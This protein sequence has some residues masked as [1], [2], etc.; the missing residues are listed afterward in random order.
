M[1]LPLR[2]AQIFYLVLV[3]GLGA[4]LLLEVGPLLGKA[5]T[6]PSLL[7][8]YLLLAMVAVG[9]VSWLITCLIDPGYVVAPPADGGGRHA[10]DTYE[11][12]GLL[13]TEKVC[14]TCHVV[15]PPRSK[16]CR[17]CNRCV[18]RFDHHCGWMNSCV[19]ERN[20]P[21]FLLF[22]LIHSTACVFGSYLSAAVLGGECEAFLDIIRE[23]RRASGAAP[24]V[25]SWTTCVAYSV[26]HHRVVVF[27]FILLLVIGIVL[28]LFF[29]FHA[30]LVYRNTTTNEKFK[31]EDLKEDMKEY[32]ERLETDVRDAEAEQAEPGAKPAPS[33]RELYMRD[34]VVLRGEAIAGNDED[35]GCE[36]AAASS[37]ED[38]GGDEEEDD[39]D[40]PAEGARRR[41]H[42][43]RGDE[44][45]RNSG[46]T[47]ADLARRPWLKDEH[48]LK[49]Y[50]EGKRK[51]RALNFYNRGFLGNWV[52]VLTA[53]GALRRERREHVARLEKQE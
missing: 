34:V 26:V 45:V 21:F 19:G 53:G 46:L 18:R 25:T 6:S 37:K 7:L 30:L 33:L 43:A 49:E 40:E 8:G 35:G 44:A 10:E 4:I 48:A 14:A 27:G 51:V 32:F 52:E 3:G 28:F 15:R 39:D 47:A 13:Y 29:L 22:L 41:A 9:I 24:L 20:Y 23:H 11:Y 16:H 50:A 2:F 1:L 31:W 12:D 42:G 5:E 17:V 36:P 38:G